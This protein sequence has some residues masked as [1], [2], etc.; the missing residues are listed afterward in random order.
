MAKNMKKKLPNRKKIK[1]ELLKVSNF[2]E[3]EVAVL[4]WSSTYKAYSLIVRY[5]E[6][7]VEDEFR[8]Q[9]WFKE[10]V[11]EETEAREKEA[12]KSKKKT[13]EDKKSKK[14]LKKLEKEEKKSKSDKKKDK[15]RKKTDKSKSEVTVAEEKDD[16]KIKSTVKVKKGKDIKKLFKDTDFSIID[17]YN[18]LKDLIS[19]SQNYSLELV[20]DELLEIKKDDKTFA[21]LFIWKNK[22]YFKTDDE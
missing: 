1:D 10:A 19:Q 8:N 17:F 13:K 15:E 4:N 21:N 6:K 12:S 20:E 18:F 3:E 7:N 9:D 22:I 2:S 16:K 5:G 14:E 11:V